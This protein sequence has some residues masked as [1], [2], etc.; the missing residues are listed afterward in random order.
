MRPAPPHAMSVEVIKTT[1]G[2]L[3]SGDVFNV[4]QDGGRFLV[5]NTSLEVEL[6]LEA[7]SH[8][9][10]GVFGPPTIKKR[11]VLIKV[12]AWNRHTFSWEREVIHQCRPNLPVTVYHDP[13]P[14]IDC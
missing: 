8:R 13:D 7:H 6:D 1:I 11:Y 10:H 5:V 9:N 2:K 4:T 12:R 14:G 3:R